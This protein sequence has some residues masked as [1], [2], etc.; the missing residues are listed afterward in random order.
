M[1]TG[2]CLILITCHRFW[3]NPILGFSWLSCDT[4]LSEHPVCRCGQKGDFRRVSSC[5]DGCDG[6]GLGLTG[7]C[8][9][10]CRQVQSQAVVS[11]S[12]LFQCFVYLHHVY[13]TVPGVYL[14]SLFVYTKCLFNYTKCPFNFTRCLPQQFVRL[15]QVSL[16]Q[17]RLSKSAVYFT[18]LFACAS[19]L[20]HQLDCLYQVSISPFHL[21]IPSVDFTI[22]LPG[23]YTYWSWMLECLAF[24]TP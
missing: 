8:E 20:F 16:S 24:L 6:S 14:S 18:I 2:N 12:C 23:L 13:L 19:C 4:G 10:L 5:W 11:L 1:V 7:Q 3:N 15:Y 22:S 21:S 17:S 9:A